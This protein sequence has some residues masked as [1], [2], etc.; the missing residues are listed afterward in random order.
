VTGGGLRDAAGLGAVHQ[1]VVDLGLVGP[2][3]SP[4]L[5]HVEGQLAEIHGGGTARGAG[6]LLLQRLAAPQYPSDSGRSVVSASTR[7]MAPWY[8]LQD[9]KEKEYY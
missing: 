6:G 9:R 5:G 1:Q 8:H 3:A 4:Q 2:E 7:V